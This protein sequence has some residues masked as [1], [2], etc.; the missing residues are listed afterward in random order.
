MS[1]LRYSPLTYDISRGAKHRLRSPNQLH[2]QLRDILSKR[3]GWSFFQAGAN[4]GVLDDPYREFIFNQG[5]HGVLVEPWLEFFTELRANYKH[6][7]HRLSFLNAAVSYPAQDLTFFNLNAERASALGLAPSAQGM[8]GM[9]RAPL[10]RLLKKH[11]ITEDIIIS[12]TVRGYTIETL[13]KL[14]GYDRVDVLFLDLEGYE[15]TVLSSYD[16]ERLQPKVLGFESKHLKEK[17]MV[18]SQLEKRGFTLV[19]GEKD[20]LAL[21]DW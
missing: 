3:R 9:E 10:E 21:R 6:I 16:D 19:H 20:T 12:R 15:E 17:Q 13:L 4:D 1:L 7:S 14:A 11:G 5:A 8:T 18:F 2:R